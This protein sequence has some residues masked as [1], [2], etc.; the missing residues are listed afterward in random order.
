MIANRILAMLCLAAPSALP[1]VVVPTAT[2][3]STGAAQPF[4]GQ[5]KP[6]ENTNPD[7][8][9]EIKALV[10]DLGKRIEKRGKE[11]HEAISVVDKLVQ[12]FP[13]CGPKDRGVVVAALDKCFTVKRQE[14]Q[15]GVRDNKLYIACAVALRTMAPESAKVL[16]TWI[17]S[18]EHK[19]DVPLQEK[20]IQ[21][22]GKTKDEAGRK[23]LIKL[24]NDKNS[25]ILAASAEALGEYGDIDLKLRKETFEELLKLLM[26]AKA[27]NDAGQASNQSDPI[28]AEKYNT[29]AAPIISALQKL[30][31]HDEHD[32]NEWQRWWNK[33]KRENWDEKDA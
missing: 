9:P 31:K 27:A 6:A 7:N 20:L 24:L 8:R 1:L 17:G 4:S 28:A 11:D 19:K 23:F 13:K 30:A 12:E 2:A 5:E 15:E 10:E 14:D 25:R 18:K 16:M 22:L 3:S 33:N 21:S 26:E 32:P 29:I